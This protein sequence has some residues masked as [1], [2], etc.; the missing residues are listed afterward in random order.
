MNEQRWQN[1]LSLL[2]GLYVVATPWSIPYF[3]PPTSTIPVIEMVEWFTGL[4]IVIVSLS[5]LWSLMLWN[6]WLK[7]AIGAWLVVAPWMIGF[8]HNVPFAYNDVVLGVLL[9]AIGGTTL[10]TTRHHIGSDL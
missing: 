5:G 3:F 9:V 7:L 2:L 10:A 4:T 6:E 8:S 1:W